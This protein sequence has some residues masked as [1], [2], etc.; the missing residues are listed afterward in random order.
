MDLGIDD[1]QFSARKRSAPSIK[2]FLR[3]VF[4]W[5]GWPLKDD[6]VG[7]LAQFRL[8]LAMPRIS[9]ALMVM[10]LRPLLP[11]KPVFVDR[12]AWMGNCWT[13]KTG[14]SWSEPL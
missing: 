7:I 6:D 3:L 9:A 12:A 2:S 10:A 5:K 11:A 14:W 13:G 8:R 1:G 4:Q